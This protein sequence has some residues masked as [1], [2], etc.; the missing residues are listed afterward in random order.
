MN[1]PLKPRRV[2]SRPLSPHLFIYKPQLSS[3]FSVLHRITGVFLSLG[4][5]FFIL[6]YKTMEEQIGFYMIYFLMYYLNT[7][8]N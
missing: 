3:I 8:L 6:T 7:Y 4:L 1:A 2:W 5:I